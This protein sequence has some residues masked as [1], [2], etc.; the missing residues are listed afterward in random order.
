MSPHLLRELRLLVRE[1]RLLGTQ[2]AYR[3][4]LIWMLLAL[5]CLIP[6]AVAVLS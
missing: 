1:L 5:L 3:F 6:V 4:V 2:P